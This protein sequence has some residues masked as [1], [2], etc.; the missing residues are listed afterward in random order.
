[1]SAFIP[2]L[3]FVAHNA[4]L[5]K[6]NELLFHG[7]ANEKETPKKL[8]EEER[9]KEEKADIAATAIA[10]VLAALIGSIGMLLFSLIAS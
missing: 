2:T 5:K 6:R 9:I 1:M 10:I 7:M 4:A 3:V 8:S